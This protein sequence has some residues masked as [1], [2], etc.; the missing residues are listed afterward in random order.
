MYSQA[1]PDVVHQPSLLCLQ[2]LL[3]TQ[4]GMSLPGMRAFSEAEVK[5]EQALP[6]AHLPSKGFWLIKRPTGP[7]TAAAPSVAGKLMRTISL[8]SPRTSSSLQRTSDGL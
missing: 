4:M 5:A 7:S 1:P 6:G 2:D 8:R 3:E